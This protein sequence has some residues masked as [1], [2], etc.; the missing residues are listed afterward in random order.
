MEATDKHMSF[1]ELKQACGGFFS[2][3]VLKGFYDSLT[4]E[5]WFKRCG[6]CGLEET[7]ENTELFYD[8]RNTDCIACSHARSRRNNI[9]RRLKRQQQGKARGRP[10]KKLTSSSVGL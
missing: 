5:E 9:A 8:S 1:D 10:R 4:G 6:E 7:K 3:D 2:D